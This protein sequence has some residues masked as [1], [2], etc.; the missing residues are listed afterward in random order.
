[1]ILTKYQNIA[2]GPALDFEKFH[3]GISGI[4]LSYGIIIEGIIL[5]IFTNINNNL[6]LI[7]NRFTYNTCITFITI[8]INNHNFKIDREP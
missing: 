8:T 7:L 2:D 3:I 6:H 1:M 4:M 5:K